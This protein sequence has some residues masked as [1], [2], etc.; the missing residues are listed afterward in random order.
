VVAHLG[1]EH[2]MIVRV[3]TN[4][5][6][7]TR[8]KWRIQRHKHGAVILF[9]NML[10]I[11]HPVCGDWANE[12]MRWMDYGYEKIHMFCELCIR[13]RSA[14]PFARLTMPPRLC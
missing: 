13:A 9:R 8:L 4:N 12:A 14:M 5:H 11:I 6:L 10:E 1:I 7:R 2:W 3:S